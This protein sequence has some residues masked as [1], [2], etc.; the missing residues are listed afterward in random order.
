MHRKLLP[1]FNTTDC[2]P[3]RR[4]ALLEHAIQHDRDAVHKH[5][6]DACRGHIIGDLE[7]MH[8]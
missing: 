2:A 5:M 8:D 7:T 3:G 1:L 6:R 4:Q